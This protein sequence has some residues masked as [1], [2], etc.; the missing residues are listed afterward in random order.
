MCRFRLNLVVYLS[1]NIFCRI[2][3]A[4][5]GGIA[6]F[7]NDGYKKSNLKVSIKFIRSLD[8]YVPIFHA[9]STIEAF[10]ELTYNYGPNKEEYYWRARKSGEQ[11]IFKLFFVSIKVMLNSKD[12][13]FCAHHKRNFKI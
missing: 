5:N 3:G 2:N 11:H 4:K 7:M 13:N 9:Y 1:C 12:Q 6:A 10:E 8:Q